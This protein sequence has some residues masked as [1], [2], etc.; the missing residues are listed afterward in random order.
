MTKKYINKISARQDCKKKKNNKSKNNKKDYETCDKREVLSK[1]L[2]KIL[3][4]YLFPVY[5]I[6]FKSS[7]VNICVS[8]H[9]QF[10][11]FE[12]FSW[13]YIHAAS[14]ECLGMETYYPEFLSCCCYR[15]ILSRPILPLKRISVSPKTKRIN[16][17]LPGPCHAE[18]GGFISAI[19]HLFFCTIKLNSKLEVNSPIEL[20]EEK[21]SVTIRYVIYS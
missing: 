17:V 7:E 19:K 5:I 14:R 10:N 12:F 18:V 21:V 8:K 11:V 13:K 15:K 4:I 1:I 3:F 2:I 20:S 9:W 16:S 6:V